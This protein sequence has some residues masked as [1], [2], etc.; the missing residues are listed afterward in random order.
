MRINQKNV[1]METESILY[2]DTSGDV[3]SNC[4]VFFTKFKAAKGKEVHAVLSR[5]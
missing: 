4:E 1:A 2:D 5:A 3:L